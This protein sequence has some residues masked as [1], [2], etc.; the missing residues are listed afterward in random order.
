MFAYSASTGYSGL[1]CHEAM[2]KPLHQDSSLA[3]GK[4]GTFDLVITLKHSICQSLIVLFFGLHFA[5]PG[6][7]TVQLLHINFTSHTMVS[8]PLSSYFAYPGDLTVQLLH[9]NLSRT[10]SSPLPSPPT[11]THFIISISKE[12]ISTVFANFSISSSVFCF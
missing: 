11:H 9:I 1:H 3:T 8:P 7:L 2:N 4:N 5:Y 12:T 10:T 6:D